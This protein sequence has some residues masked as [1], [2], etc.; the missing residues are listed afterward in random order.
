M[1]DG[2]VVPLMSLLDTYCYRG[3]DGRSRWSGRCP[4]TPSDDARGGV[5]VARRLH[6]RHEARWS[7]GSGAAAADECSLRRALAAL[8]RALAGAR[9]LLDGARH[10]SRQALLLAD[11]VEGVDG[12]ILVRLVDEAGDGEGGEG[13][14][15]RRCG[16]GGGCLRRRRSDGGWVRC[17]RWGWRRSWCWCCSWRASGG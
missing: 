15:P 11:E 12:R 13:W 6:P 3:V 2:E 17:R 4:T 5:G 16:G 8:R 7:G 14:H 10:V 9:Q 1:D